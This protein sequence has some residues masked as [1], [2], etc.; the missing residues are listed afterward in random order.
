[1]FEIDMN[2]IDEHGSQHTLIATEVEVIDEDGDVTEAVITQRTSDDKYLV[3]ATNYFAKNFDHDDSEPL[4][5]NLDLIDH[6]DEY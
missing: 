6:D 1:M 5:N 4:Q 3:V 2:Y